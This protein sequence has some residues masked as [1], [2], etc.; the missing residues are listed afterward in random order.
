LNFTGNIKRLILLY[1]GMPKQVLNETVNI[2]ITPQHYIIKRKELPV[3]YA[4]QAKKV[5]PSVF[6]G[7]LEDT[8]DYAYYVIKQ[9]ENLWDF[10]AYNPDEIKNDLENRGIP[11]EKVSRLYFA[12]E[13]ANQIT[14][15][16]QVNDETALLTVN[17]TAVLVP[18]S[19]LS[20]EERR[21]ELS[22]LQTPKGGISLKGGSS[23]F[24]FEQIASL[25]AILV[26]F[27]GMLLYEGIRYGGADTQGKAEITKILKNNPSLESKYTR[28]SIA[29]KYKSLDTQE[30]QKRAII[31]RLSRMIF[32]G[33]TLDSLH[34]DTK[35]FN[36]VFQINDENMLQKF[37]QLA[38]KEKFT[39]HVKNPTT[40]R[41][42]GSL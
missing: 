24:D 5:A 14:T 2:L 34:I 23:R 18:A 3:K 30:R 35:K 42:E 29:D 37:K 32:K 25:S 6:D 13:F 11:L 20:E 31:K 27:A 22:S 16:I 21:L 8:Q 40:V 28:E 4:Y 1:K 7:L 38:A 17:D 19:A 12:Q 41:V 36:A 10:I 39:V 9:D 15:P 33:V 26:L